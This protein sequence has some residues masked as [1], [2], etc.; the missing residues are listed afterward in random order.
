M[1]GFREDLGYRLWRIGESVW[2]VA[3][4]P[5][6]VAA[7]WALQSMHRRPRR[8]E[9]EAQR[10]FSERTEQIHCAFYERRGQ[11]GKEENERR[12]LEEFEALLQER[13]ERY[14]RGEYP[15]HP[16]LCGRERGRP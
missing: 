13:R 16:K 3:R 7:I 4:D 12:F 2:E 1:K 5:V 11:M 15:Y 6:H 8:K 10:W 9:T 14:S